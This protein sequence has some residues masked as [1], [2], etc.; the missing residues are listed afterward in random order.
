[1]R[2][3]LPLLAL[4]AIPVL[5]RPAAAQDAPDYVEGKEAAQ[6]TVP[7]EG[8]AVA[9]QPDG[10]TH[11]LSLGTNFSFGHSSNVV[12]SPD[13]GTFQ[14]G[15]LLDGAASLRH[16][17]HVW[18][19]ALSVTHTQTKTPA[20]DPFV[21]TVD[22]FNLR[23]TYLYELAKVRWLGPFARVRFQTSLLPGYLVV[24]EPRRLRITDTDGDV[25]T[26]GLPAQENFELTSAFEPFLMRQSTGVFARPYDKKEIQLLTTLG[27]GAQEVFTQAGL[28]VTDD[29]T[30]TPLELTKL[31]DS[32]QVG[33]EVEV[34]ASGEWQQDLTWGASAN[35]LWPFVVDAD[36]DLEGADLVNVEFG[37]KLGYKLSKW[38]SLDYVLSAKKVPLI[39]DAWQVQNNLLLTAAFNLL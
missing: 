34:V 23:S 12:G 26:R 38:A 2:T 16:G 28:A 1:M 25:T 35:V 17:Q 4:A 31:A 37:L 22:D 36:T 18:Q 19:N 20:I 9:A 30:T 39:V 13:G 33:A 8:E 5:A 24:A 27:L 10:W 15:L 11:K 21:K 7:K 6:A 32:V 14:V 3:L 29:D